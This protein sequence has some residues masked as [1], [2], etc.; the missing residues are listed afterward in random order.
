MP[1]WFFFPSLIGTRKP[2]L[3]MG[4]FLLISNSRPLPWNGKYGVRQLHSHFPSTSWPPQMLPACWKGWWGESPLLSNM[5]RGPCKALRRNQVLMLR[6]EMLFETGCSTQ[7]FLLWMPYNKNLWKGNTTAAVHPSSKRETLRANLHVTARP[8]HIFQEKQAQAV[9][10]VIQ[11]HER[12]RT[13]FTHGLLPSP[14]SL[15]FLVSLVVCWRSRG[16]TYCSVHIHPC[17]NV[18]S[19]KPSNAISQQAFLHTHRARLLFDG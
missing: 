9:A 16:C 13:S 19:T 6:W 10:V 17:E 3:P 14:G 12:E 7:V 15:L 8:W 2:S 5:E 11:H 1:N 18:M 4:Y